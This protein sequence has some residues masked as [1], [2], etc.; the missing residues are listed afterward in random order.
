VVIEL[1]DG[2]SNKNITFY[3]SFGKQTQELLMAAL[4]K[5]PLIKF[6]LRHSIFGFIKTL[7]VPPTK[8][9]T[10]ESG[11]VCKM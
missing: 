7:F 10:A 8:N 5:V 1:S 3:L 2:F 9:L 6:T 11:E 4:A